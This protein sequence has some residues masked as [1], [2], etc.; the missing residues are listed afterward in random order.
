M[1]SLDKSNLEN[2][3]KQKAEQVLK[4]TGVTVSCPFCNRKFIARKINENCPNCKKTLD[5]EFKV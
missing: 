2:I 5:I 3:A 1:S 4:T